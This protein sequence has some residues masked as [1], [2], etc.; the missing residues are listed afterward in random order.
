[1]HLVAQPRIRRRPRRVAPR[2]S[3][4]LR[5]RR[6]HGAGLVAYTGKTPKELGTAKWKNTRRYIRSRDGD[7][8]RLC[9]ASGAV[10]RMFTHHIKPRAQ[11]GTDNVENLMLVCQ[12]CHMRLE[13]EAQQAVAKPNSKYP[14]TPWMRRACSTDRGS[15]RAGNGTPT[16]SPTPPPPERQRPHDRPDTL[17]ARVADQR[18]TRRA[19]VATNGERFF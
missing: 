6:E 11:G 10:Q 16:S 3:R 1:M 15:Q 13:R 8:C 2:P 14:A 12:S 4:L 18:E 7:R 5:T 17:T 9:Q 19:E